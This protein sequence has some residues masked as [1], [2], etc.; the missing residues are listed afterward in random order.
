MPVRPFVPADAPAWVTLHHAVWNR[1]VSPDSLLTEDAARPAGQVS[2]RW[3][4]EDGGATGEGGQVAGTA[5]LYFFP[6]LPPKFLQLDIAV[7]PDFRGRGHGSA[8]WETA[9]AAAQALGAVSLATNVGADTGGQPANGLCST[10]KPLGTV[11]ARCAACTDRAC[12][13]L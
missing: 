10:A 6:F 13:R 9:H 5:H 7:S 1:A 4:I 12:N 3:V 11:P 2:R 8:L